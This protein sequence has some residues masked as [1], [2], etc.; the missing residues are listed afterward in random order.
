MKG[1][2][3]V[4]GRNFNATGSIANTRPLSIAGKLNCDQ[5]NTTCDYFA[6]DLDYVK[7]QRS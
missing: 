4:T 6:G 1:D 5:V 3:V 2:G 7:I